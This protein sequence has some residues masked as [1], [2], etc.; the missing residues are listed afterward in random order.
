M[1]ISL[2]GHIFFIYL[3][4]E[5][6]GHMVSVWLTVQETDSLFSNVAAPFYTPTSAVVSVPHPLPNLVLLDFL[7]LVMLLGV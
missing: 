6:L 5:C 3:G 1:C 4:A 7:I 2:E